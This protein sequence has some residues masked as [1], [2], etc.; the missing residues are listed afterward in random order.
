MIGSIR[1]L[2]F[3]TASLRRAAIAPVGAILLLA[4]GDGAAQ[5][6][7]ATIGGFVTDAS[8]AAIPGAAV[9][10]VN[11]GTQASAATVSAGSGSGR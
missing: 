5:P 3:R 8:G 7:Y 1:N 9:S 6:T 2:L 4:T 10:L 11:L